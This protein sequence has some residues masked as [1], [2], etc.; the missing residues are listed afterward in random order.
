MSKRNKTV[1]CKNYKNK[2]IDINLIKQIE[3]LQAQKQQ[4][5]GK[6]KKVSFVEISSQIEVKFK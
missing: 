6:K 1:G 5:V 3:L 2:P 4:Q